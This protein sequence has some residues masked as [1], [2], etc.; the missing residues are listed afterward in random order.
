MDH[1]INIGQFGFYDKQY[2]YKSLLVNIIY[3][4]NMA[5]N[6]PNFMFLIRRYRYD[7]RKSSIFHII[8]KY[9]SSCKF[10]LLP[11]PDLRLAPLK[12]QHI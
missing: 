4:R 11:N 7:K 3:V 9:R 1:Q 2:L 12:L 8:D 6:M 5:E 10:V